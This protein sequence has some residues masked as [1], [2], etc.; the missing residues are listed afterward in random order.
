MKVF[1]EVANS[2]AGS[3]IK[4]FLK[5][6]S[7]EEFKNHEEVFFIARVNNQV[8][9]GN[10]AEVEERYLHICAFDRSKPNSDG[11]LSPRVVASF[12]AGNWIGVRLISDI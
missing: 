7:F 4:V 1:E 2:M 3:G 6:G 9:V 12:P 10:R 11:K 5:D 8:W